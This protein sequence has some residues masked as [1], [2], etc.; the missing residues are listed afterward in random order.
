MGFLWGWWGGG[1]REKKKGKDKGKLRKGRE[2]GKND[3]E[4]RR[5]GF[6]IHRK[7]KAKPL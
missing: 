3:E 7:K 6:G 5:K 1:I 2:S 4:R